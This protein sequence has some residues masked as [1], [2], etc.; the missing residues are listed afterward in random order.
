MTPEEEYNKLLER[1]VKGAKKIENPLLDEGKR[2]QY[3]ELYNQLEQ[4]LLE[5]KK[6]IFYA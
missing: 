2:V 6:V 4:R 3:M 1:M 5:I